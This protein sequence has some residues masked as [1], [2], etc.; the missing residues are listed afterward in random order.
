MGAWGL[1]PDGKCSARG[2]RR[3][4]GLKFCCGCHRMTSALDLQHAAHKK[5]PSQERAGTIQ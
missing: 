3:D 1:Y 2:A 5:A 4:G